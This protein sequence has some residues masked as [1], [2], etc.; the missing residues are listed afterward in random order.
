MKYM[1]I[2]IQLSGPPLKIKL[3]MVFIIIIL[4]YKLNLKNQNAEFIY[5]LVYLLVT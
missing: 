3:W 4:Q 5:A 1:E 2:I